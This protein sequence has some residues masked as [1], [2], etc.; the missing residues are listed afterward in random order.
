MTAA[1]DQLKDPWPKK[2]ATKVN[3]DEKELK[4]KLK[5]A[6]KELYVTCAISQPVYEKRETD[7]AGSNAVRLSTR[8]FSGF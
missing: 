7:F 5:M 2:F 1:M 6:I 8:L 3:E 4:N